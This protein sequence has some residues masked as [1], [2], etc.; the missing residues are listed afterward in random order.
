MTLTFDDIVPQM[1]KAGITVNKYN[2]GPDGAAIFSASASV[3]GLK[4]WPGT[5]EFE[6]ATDANHHQA[7]LSVLEGARGVSQTYNVTLWLRGAKITEATLSKD[8]RNTLRRQAEAHFRTLVP[9]SV[10]SY[11]ILKITK[12]DDPVRGTQRQWTGSDGSY[13]EHRYFFQIRGTRTAR[14]STNH[15][16][17]GI[18]ETSH[19]ISLLPR[20]ATSVTDAHKALRPRGLRSSTI[21]QGEFFF[22][23]VTPARSAVLTEEFF[24][25]TV[26]TEDRRAKDGPRGYQY[27]SFE[28]GL[29]RPLEFGSSHRALTMR[30]EDQ[31]YVRGWVTDSRKGRHEPLWL[32]DWHKVVRNQEKIETR[33]AAQGGFHP[34]PRR[35]D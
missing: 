11:K 1:R 5:A 30:F 13:T 12:D 23:P 33:T 34:T 29:I 25:H 19:F 20:K 10:F 35:W 24:G 2:R 26:T 14:R 31:L 28:P 21:R 27:R 16:L 22:E 32:E 8:A 15:L 7:V 18:D 17:M 9:N 4:I 3:T 6:V